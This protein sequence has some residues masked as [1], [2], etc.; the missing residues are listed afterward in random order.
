MTDQTIVAV[1]DT[2]ADAQAAIRDLEAAG[3]ARG[4]IETHAGAD[5]Q[6]QSERVETGA[7]E[8]G[9]FFAWLFGDDTPDHDRAVYQDSLG[10]GG[11]VVSVRTAEEDRSEVIALLE[12]NNPVNVD[13]RGQ[14]LGYAT[15]ANQLAAT[16]EPL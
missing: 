7:H 10:R 15:P 13:E 9:G 6:V 3:I 2:M 14:S 11:S 1:Y 12:R 16:S 5:T 8:G 4:A